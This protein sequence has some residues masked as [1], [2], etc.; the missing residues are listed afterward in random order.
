MIGPIQMPAELQSQRRGMSLIELLVVVAIIGALVALLLPAVGTAR[1]SARRTQC[2]NNLRQM[3]IAAHIFA[4]KHAGSYPIAYH[5][6]QDGDTS[7]AYCW[8]ITLITKPNQP[9][10]V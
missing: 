2:L 7:Y 1:E 6:K 10:V 9:A 3:I 5:N 8:D 4:D